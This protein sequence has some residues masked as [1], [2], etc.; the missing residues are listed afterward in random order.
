[1]EGVVEVPNELRLGNGGERV[2]ERQDAE[3]GDIGAVVVECMR[4]DRC[5]R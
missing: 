1:M 3:L 5:D 4:V 2:G